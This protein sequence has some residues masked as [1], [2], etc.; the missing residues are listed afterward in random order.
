MTIT[1]RL[2]AELEKRLR[3]AVA[4]EQTNLSDFIRVVLEA[5]LDTQ[6]AEPRSLKEA[7]APV[8]GAVGS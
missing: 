7:A 3:R 8:I 2:P 6:D 1:V 4:D 5:R